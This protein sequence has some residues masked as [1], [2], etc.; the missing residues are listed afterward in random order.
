MGGPS[1]QEY[2]L[3]QEQAA[4]TKAYVAQQSTL[5][6]ESQALQATL[7]P[8]LEKEISNPTG[9]TPQQMAD[10]NANNINTTGAQYA[11][12]Q[13]QLN[14]TNASSNMAGLTSGVGA[15]ETAALKGSAAST[16]SLNAQSTQL[17]NAQLQNTNKNIAQQQLVGM[18]SGMG[19]QAISQ[20]SLENQSNQSTFNE[21][22]TIQQQNNSDML[23]SV[24]GGAVGAASGAAFGMM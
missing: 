14:A 17:A 22:N 6:S 3:Q 24:L 11:N 12:V 13:K 19:S 23:N 9:F 21:A 4:E 8:M 18:Q 10:L 2:N 15:A 7:T 1:Q 20:G 5:F 16:V